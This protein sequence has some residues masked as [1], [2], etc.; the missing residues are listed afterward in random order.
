MNAATTAAAIGSAALASASLCLYLDADQ[1]SK[2]AQHSLRNL[3][4][5]QLITAL[6]EKDKII[7]SEEKEM[8]IFSKISTKAKVA[9]GIGVAAIGGGIAIDQLTEKTP[10]DKTGIAGWWEAKNKWGLGLEV[11]GGALVTC[12]TGKS[13]KDIRAAKKRE[14]EAAELQPV[15]DPEPAV[16]A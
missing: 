1:K 2:Q 12:A 10:T 4:R 9:G 16:Q 8:A 3:S 6:A 5:L 11:G 14:A 7:R 15:A 13:I